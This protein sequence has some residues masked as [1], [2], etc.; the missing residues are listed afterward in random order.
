MKPLTRVRSSYPTRVVRYSRTSH[1]WR[2]RSYVALGVRARLH[3]WHHGVFISPR[4]RRKLRHGKHRSVT[5]G[6]GRGA[7]VF[8]PRAS[9]HRLK[10]GSVSHFANHPTAEPNPTHPYHARLCSVR[11]ETNLRAC[12]VAKK[13]PSSH[14]VVARAWLSFQ[15]TPLPRYVRGVFHVTWTVS[16][17]KRECFVRR[18]AG[19][20]A[21][22][23]PSRRGDETQMQ[24]RF[25]LVWKLS[26]PPT[27]VWGGVTPRGDT[28]APPPAPNEQTLTFPSYTPLPTPP[29]ITQA[30]RVAPVVSPDAE[31]ASSARD[32][33]AKLA[34]FREFRG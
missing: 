11:S 5:R 21:P 24:E 1:V 23:R 28:L 16:F 4:E 26:H 25:P 19:A 9:R 8:T 33:P 27:R 10:C 29:S 6:L 7:T 31:R 22:F 3:W 32:S 12:Q 2:A 20:H 30:A 18:V 13:A 14:A 17:A 15:G 34:S